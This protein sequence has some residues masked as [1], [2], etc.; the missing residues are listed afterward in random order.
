MSRGYPSMTALLALLAMAGYQNRD[1]IAEWLNAAQRKGGIPPQAPQG[2]AGET[3]PGNL[4]GILGGTSI[5][6]LLSGGLRDLVNTF[7]QAGHG[8]VA[9]SWISRGPNK[10]IAPSQL[11]QAIGS[12]VLQAIGSDV[13]ETLSQQTGLSREEILSRLSKNLP[14]AVDKYTPDG[15]VPTVADF[16]RS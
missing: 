10:Q 15:R 7:K 12:D 6:D 8:D 16:S 5:G 3:L 13:L 9:D 11:E 4:G 1:K 2:S 14:D